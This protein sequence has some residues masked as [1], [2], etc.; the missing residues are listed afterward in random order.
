MA[1]CTETVSYTYSIRKAETTVTKREIYA[2]H[3]FQ[4]GADAMRLTVAAGGGHTAR[5]T[6]ANDS[7]DTFTMAFGVSADDLRALAD[8]LTRAADAIAPS[9]PVS[10]MTI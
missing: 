3:G 4:C 5:V 9:A 1:R 7:T 6:L 10:C 2:H 8:L